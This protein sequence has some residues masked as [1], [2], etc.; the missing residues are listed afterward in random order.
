MRWFTW[1]AVLSIATAACALEPEVGPRFAGACDNADAHPE[2]NVSFSAQIRP[3]FD[4]PGS[5]G[6][7]GCHMPNATGA[8]TG[9]QLSGLNLSSLAA[10]RMGG[11]TS[12]SR[13]VVSRE[14]CSS[15]L[16]LKVEDAPPFGSRM[17]LSG[18]PFLTDAETDLIHDWIAEGALDN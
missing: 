12:G 3:L 2:A 15:I 16:Y 10:L 13:V 17:P 5:M 1:S 4:R 8:S 9:I 18:P 14:P 6:G 7:C 11:F